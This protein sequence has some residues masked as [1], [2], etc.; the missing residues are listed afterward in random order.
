MEKI[1]S[2]ELLA[3]IKGARQSEAVNELFAVIREAF[4]DEVNDDPSGRAGEN[5]IAFDNLRDDVAIECPERERDL[6]TGNF[7]GEKNGYLS[8]SKVIED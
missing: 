8:V 1:M 4:P 2:L 5:I 3:G 7:P 6:I